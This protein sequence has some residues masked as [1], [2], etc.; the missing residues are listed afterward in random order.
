[1]TTSN[2]PVQKKKKRTKEKKNDRSGDRT[3]NVRIE[4][5]RLNHSA[6]GTTGRQDGRTVINY[7]PDCGSSCGAISTR[8]DL[9]LRVNVESPNRSKLNSKSTHEYPNVT[10]DT[11]MTAIFAETTNL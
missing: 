3:H 6:I 2:A 11:Q 4:P 1:M 7:Y 8:S 5:R 9:S 10:Q